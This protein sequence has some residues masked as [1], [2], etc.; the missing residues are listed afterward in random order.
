MNWIRKLLGQ[1][2]AGAALVSCVVAAAVLLA[3]HNGVWEPLELAAYDGFIRLKTDSAITHPHIVV[4]GITEEDI[5]QLGHWPL[6]DITLAEAVEAL[7]RQRPRAIGLDLFRD[8]PVPPGTDKFYRLLTQNSQIVAVMKF[9]VTGVQAP[10][11]LQGSQQVGFNDIIVDPGGT[12]RRALL[13]LDDGIQVY[14][15]FALRLAMLFLQA[16]GITPQPDPENPQFIRLGDRT[17]VPF[18]TNNGCYIRAD[19]RGYQFLLDYDETRMVFATY[20]LTQL[21]S[22]QIGENAVRDKVVLIGVMAQSVK[23]LFYTPYSRGFKHLQQVP[24]VFVHAHAGSQLLRT[25]LNQSRPIRT[26][27]EYGEKLWIIIWSLLGGMVGLKAWSP[28]RFGVVSTAGVLLVG[29]LSLVAYLSRIWMPVIAPAA[30]WLMSAAAVTA[31]ISNREKKQRSLLMNLFSRHVSPEVAD[32]IWQ[33]RDRFLNNGRPRSQSLTITV[34]FSDL[35]GF[36]PVAERMEAEALI[37]WLNTYL[38]AMVQI[39]MDHGGVIDDYAGDGIKANFGVP[40]PRQTKDEIRQD[41]VNAVRCALAMEDELERLNQDWRQNGLPGVGIRVGIHTGSAVAGAL[42]S[43]RRLKYT[44]VGDTVNTAAHLEN[45]RKEIG[46]DR[47]CRIFI[48]DATLQQLDG[49]FRVDP[50]AEARLKGKDDT[51]QIYQVLEL[52]QHRENFK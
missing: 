25:A 30:S 18:E 4:I 46:R 7:L 10:D 17:I 32:A 13:F 37:D 41:A 11:F 42:G 48:S 40:F 26:I 27:S 23:D 6:Q 3:W 49:R 28:W 50:V 29:G 8:L 15:S 1:P 9:G 24:G 2:V 47:P 14:Y 21:L 19:A 45:Y 31:Y 35:R 52:H 34:L 33:Q 43:H 36:T 22:G 12:V 39:I 44:T 16:E 38:E 20:S 51:I 5:Q